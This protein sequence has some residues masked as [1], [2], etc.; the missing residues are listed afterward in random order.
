MLRASRLR[1]ACRIF[2]VTAF[3]L[4]SVYT[5]AAGTETVLHQFV[6]LSRGGFPAS[7]LVADSQGNFYGT[8][9]GGGVYGFGTVFELAQN[10]AG[11]WSQTV[12]YNF[13]GLADGNNSIV[14]QGGGLVLDKSGNLYGTTSEGGSSTCYCGVVFELSP[15]SNGSWTETVLY[16]FTGGSTDGGAPL[17][18]LVFDG[19]ENLFGTTQFGGPTSVG[20]CPTSC[21]TVFQLTHSSSGWT[22]KIVHFF[23]GVNEGTNPNAGMVLDSK[24]NLFGT[25]GLANDIASSVFQLAHSSA[26]WK[27]TPLHSFAS[28]GDASNPNGLVI[29]SA[30]N[31]FGSSYQ[32]GA[33]G[34]GAV[35]EIARGSAG[36]TETLLYSFQ[37][38][39]DGLSP[40][41]NV[42]FDASGNLYGT[43]Y[44]GGSSKDGVVYKLTPGGSGTWTES[45]L[46]SFTGKSDGANPRA[47]ITIDPSGNIFGTT[48][49]GSTVNVGTIFEL[50][51]S[52]GYSESQIFSFPATDGDQIIGGLVADSAGNLYGTADTGGDYLCPLVGNGCGSVFKLARLSNGTW[53]RTTLHTFTGAQNDGAGPQAGLI[54]DSAGNLYGTTANSIYGGGTIF[55]LSPSGTGWTFRTI[56]GFGSRPNDGDDP[57]GNLIID[58]S[59]N[60]YGT[61]IR[62]G[63]GSYENC[64]YCGTVFELSP[65]GKGG[66]KESV[67]YNFQGLGD[68]NFP[69]A[70]LVLDGAGNLYGTTTEGGQSG[71]GVVFKLAPSSSGTWTQSVLYTFG[72]TS[73]GGIPQG[74]VVLDSSGNLYGTAVTGGSG[75]HCNFGCGVVYELT[76]TSSGPWNETV[77]YNF[78]GFP[79]GEFPTAGLTFNAGNLYGTTNGGG[80][81][82]NPYCS[83]GCGTVFKLTP[84]SGGWTE[85][86]VYS[87]GGPLTDGGNPMAGVILD[88]A[89]KI[90]GTTSVGGINGYNYLSGG[91]VFQISQ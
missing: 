13:T 64:N 72:C 36:W 15:Q 82:T 23:T 77:V 48:Y 34:D 1:S 51:A 30:G 86:V 26:G 81:D 88:S 47:A 4:A 43:T 12:I 20:P 44:D 84:A 65:N 17:G 39:T 45:V 9:A 85:S 7:P 89:G 29:D 67:I 8:T 50:V 54:F 78:G 32:G 70:G 38:G 18:S 3:A 37:G 27:L 62:G 75:P 91:T 63:T 25:T 11:K 46:Y 21:G 53:Q 55:R 35:F 79:D 14:Y 6:N 58:G 42:T 31:L 56:Y 83:Q 69:M 90:Y 52:G 2:F 87:F 24:G 80:V 57:F 10:S 41:A 61:T 68:G 73:D 19:D 28:S 66:W 40:L 22:E 5:A 33:N 49:L 74:G 60:F 59:G 71:C 16:S 76:P